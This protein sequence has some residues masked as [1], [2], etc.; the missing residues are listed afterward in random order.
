MLSREPQ[1]LELQVRLWPKLT[2]S[3]TINIGDVRN[4]GKGRKLPE[5]KSS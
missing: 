3:N 5:N 4:V 2:K 1:F